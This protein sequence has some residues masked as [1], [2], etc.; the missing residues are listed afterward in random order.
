MQ[1]LYLG[2]SFAAVAALV[3]CDGSG[4]NANTELLGNSSNSSSESVDEYDGTVE[5]FGDLPKCSEKKDGKVYYVK[6]EGVSYTCQYDVDQEEGKWTKK[7]KKSA[8]DGSSSSNVK[9]D[10]S[11]DTE[12]M[13]DE[14][15]GQTYKTVKIGNQVWMAENLNYR[16]LGPT[17]ALD[18]SSFCYK[19]DPAYCETYGRLYL[20]SAA[21][22]S[23]GIIK[24]NEAN[25]CGDY[26]EC[27]PSGTVR[28][29]CPR[30]WHLPSRAE[31]EVLFTTVG[32]SD[33]AGKMLIS[34]TGWEPW[35]WIGN[36]DVGFSALP[37]GIRGDS[38][39][40]SD[41]NA[42]FWSST[43]ADGYGAYGVWLFYGEDNAYLSAPEK[44]WGL[45]VR[46][47]KD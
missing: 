24:G 5:E 4:T 28:G 37:A 42:F 29:V 19:D 7:K 46:C 14:R 44:F 36:I 6:D 35:A 27:T 23:A 33:V 10:E 2:L 34:E 1:K 40:Y 30:G 26:L 25:G 13:T 21:M 22:D 15:D 38:G 32:G 12:T 8:D 9:P 39:K 3:A 18:S 11:D 20:W 43:D 47:V 41:G 45:S 17:L 16:Y 31:W